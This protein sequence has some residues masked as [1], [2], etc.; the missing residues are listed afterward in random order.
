MQDPTI[1]VKQIN[2]GNTLILP[3]IVQRGKRYWP[4]RVVC[5]TMGINWH[6]QLRKISAEPFHPRTL[7]VNLTGSGLSPEYVLTQNEF[8]F[9]LMSLSQ[10]KISDKSRGTLIQIRDALIGNHTNSKP[11]TI[12]QSETLPLPPSDLTTQSLL[13]I[14]EI[15]AKK[16]IGSLVLSRKAHILNS[17]SRAFGCKINKVSD[18]QLVPAMTTLC[19]VISHIDDSKAAGITPL[20]QRIQTLVDHLIFKAAQTDLHHADASA[21]VSAVE[22]ENII[23]QPAK[24]R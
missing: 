21:L 3:V 6:N 11:S 2:I 7:E 13:K 15:G 19:R 14:V 22:L 4:V 8:N 24:P 12:Q 18:T 5:Q 10:K 1:E 16:T 20:S 23:H 17:F 9:W